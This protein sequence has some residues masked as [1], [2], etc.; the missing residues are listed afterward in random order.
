MN[1]NKTLKIIFIVATVIV[2]FIYRDTIKNNAMRVFGYY[3][4]CKAPISY[5]ISSFDTRFGISKSNFL[6]AMKEA[7]AIWEKPIGINLFQYS[8]GGNL[9]VN[10]IYDT[11]QASTVK[12]QSMG[13]VVKNS[14]ASYDELKSKYDSLTLDYQN[15]K[16]AFEARVTAFESRKSIYEAEVS[17]ANKRGGADKQTYASLNT[18]RNYLNSEIIAINNLQDSLNTEAQNINALIQALNSLATSLNLDVKKYNA[19][20]DNLGGEFDEGLYK[21]DASG[22]EID[23]YQFEDRTK[24]V[25]VLAHEMGHALGLVHVDDPKAIMYRLNI[26]QNEKLSDTDLSQLKS[27][28]GIK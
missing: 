20:G 16:A 5:D 9:K 27:F 18:E 23:I 22:E 19:I 6:S 24:L 8:P 3:F 17:A 1:M 10:L 12:L 4:P 26:G 28:C 14:Q 13:I 2:G 7:E 11:R 15:Q 25:R 21:S